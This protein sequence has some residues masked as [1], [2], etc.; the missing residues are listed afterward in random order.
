VIVIVMALCLPL[1]SIYLAR[2]TSRRNCLLL[3]QTAVVLDPPGG[4]SAS[5]MEES[6]ELFTDDHMAIDSNDKVEP[7][8]DGQVG[9]RVS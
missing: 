5:C 7:W 2:G 9:T 8:L 3:E 4:L 1:H 6:A